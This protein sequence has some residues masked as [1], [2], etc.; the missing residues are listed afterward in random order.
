[1]TDASQ[2]SSRQP[3]QRPLWRN[4]SFTLMWTSTAASGFGDRMI[5]LAA[6]ALLG[7]LV[8]GTL[9]STAIQASTQF[10]FFL[11]YVLISAL[12]G[13]LADHLPRK[14]LLLSCDEAR[15]IILFACYFLL[16]EASGTADIDR[17]LVWFS[18]AGY[19]VPTFW[20]VYLALFLI[21]CFAATFNPTRNA[22]IPQ[23]IPTPQLQAANAV[24]LVITVIASLVGMVVGERIISQEAADSVRFGL[25]L[26]GL[27]YLVSGTFFAFLKPVEP[28]KAI[29]GSR[30]TI[31]QAVRYALAHRRVM[32][33]I[34]LN[35]LIWASAAAVSSGLMGIGKTHH[36]LHGDALL[37]M[38]AR[39]SVFLGAGMLVGSVVIIAIRTRRE[40]TLFTML[41]V[42]GAGVGV[43]V[44]SIVPLLWVTYAA[45]FFVGLCGNVAIIALVTILQ[46]ITP[47]YIRGRTMGLNSMVNTIFSVTTYFLIWQLPD[48]DENIVRVMFVLGPALI[49]VGLLGMA[50][51]L[52]VG[53]MPA[54]LANAIWHANRAY[55]LVWHRLSFQGRGNVPTEGPVI[56]ASNHTTGIDPVLIQAGCSRV[57]RWVML[58]SFRSRLIE[59]LW[60]A[61]NPITLDRGNAGVG[62]VRKIV[63]ALEQGDLVGLFPEGGL[64][65]E[66]RELQPFQAG[67]AR[68]AQRSGAWVVPVWI[69]GTPRRRWMVW[70]FVQPSRSR[71]VYGKPYKV[72]PEAD[73]Q[74]VLDELRERMVALSGDGEGGEKS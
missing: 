57:V 42:I 43:F 7:G 66:K 18:V 16:A 47:N 58:A 2:Q 15:A 4:L 48:A 13:W 46:S 10:W 40:S 12:G 23:I 9:E 55:A 56:L 1:M 30:R 34:G 72:D 24:I 19:D 21:G 49:G 69:E 64:Q 36:D 35:V 71:V 45:A 53:P 74:Q 52:T 50:R 61:I 25:L 70:H 5:M 59:P 38:F 63:E 62:Q 22:I 29:V 65:R 6:L 8:A 67:V 51:Y 20:K 37:S 26:G 33:V 73:T 54:R 32:I 3:R 14:W 68:I 28:E 11:P 41:A 60:R 44:M 17:D 27:F 31:R 39:A